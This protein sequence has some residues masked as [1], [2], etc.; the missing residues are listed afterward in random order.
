MLLAVAILVHQAGTT[1]D[2]TNL[3]GSPLGALGQR[4]VSRL[5][6]ADELHALVQRLRLLDGI[7]VHSG[8]GLDNLE[9]ACREVWQQRS[10]M[11]RL[12]DAPLPPDSEHRIRTDL[13]DLAILSADLRVRLAPSDQSEQAQRDALALLAEAEAEFGSSVVLAQELRSYAEAL[14]LTD[15]ARQA[16]EQAEQRQPRTPWEHVAVGR[17]LLR[18][19]DPGHAAEEFERAVDEDPQA[20][21][22]NFYA[23]ICA[24]RL[25]RYEAA[26]A[27]F[28]ACIAIDPD[29]TACYYHRGLAFRCAGA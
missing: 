12:T 3:G 17:H 1:S 6:V 13:L 5:R 18:W 9:S 15:K 14:G 8:N 27:S 16:G 10:R 19:G 4:S 26:L 28:S 11:I 20:F 2:A 23:G 21:W 22:A 25:Q 24:Y 7:E 29:K